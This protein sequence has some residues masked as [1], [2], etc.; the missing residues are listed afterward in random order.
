MRRNIRFPSLAT[1]LAL[2]L[3]A[4]FAAPADAKTKRF[5]PL[6]FVPKNT[7]I[8]FTRSPVG[9]GGVGATA[10][11]A[12]PLGLPAGATIT[13]MR[14]HSN[15]VGSKRTTTLLGMSVGVP[16]LIVAKN[17]T[18]VAWPDDFTAIVTAAELNPQ[19]E[20]RVLSGDRAYLI[21]LICPSGTTIWAVDVDY[22]P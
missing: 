19:A 17:E 9:V 20:F 1:L 21:E 7:A 6:D 22:T 2:V 14:V 10:E 13:A 18:S 4:A 5:K 16:D 11:F 3:V 12:A 8:S 15:G